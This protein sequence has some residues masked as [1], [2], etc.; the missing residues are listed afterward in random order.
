MA[1]LQAAG[2]PRI[3]QGLHKGQLG[4]I[5]CPRLLVT[6]NES[7]LSEPQLTHLWGEDSQES[8]HMGILRGS[9]SVKN[10]KS[11]RTGGGMNSVGRGRRPMSFISVS[12]GELGQWQTHSRAG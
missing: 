7:L 6:F 10:V 5:N 1:P 4:G 12:L 11:P 3:P 8:H 2:G 9:K